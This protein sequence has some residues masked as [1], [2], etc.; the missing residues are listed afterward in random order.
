MASLTFY[1]DRNFGKRFPEALDRMK[2]PFKVEWQHNKSNNFPQDMRDDQW[3]E[4][5]GRNGWIAF[6]HDQKFHTVT[7]EAMAIRQHNVGCFYLPGASVP[8]FEKVQF[9]FKAYARITAV[10]ALVSRP[11][12]YRV[13]PSG[14]IQ[15]V[16]LP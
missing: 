6:S 15:Q 5:C 16:T 14:R 3:L 10:A 12:L 8:T 1:F 2:P 9:F 7:A 4:I 11:Y 13:M